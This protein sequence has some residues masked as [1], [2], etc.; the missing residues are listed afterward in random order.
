MRPNLSCRSWRIVTAEHTSIRAYVVGGRD[1]LKNSDKFRA[2]HALGRPQFK[3]LAADPHKA[4]EI[5]RSLKMVVGTVGGGEVRS[6]RR[7]RSELRRISHPRRVGGW[8]EEAAAAEAAAAA[9]ST[10]AHS[11]D[12]D[13]DG[14]L[15]LLRRRLGWSARQILHPPLPARPDHPTAADWP[16]VF[17]EALNATPKVRGD[18]IFYAGV[19][20][21]AA[22]QQAA[23]SLRRRGRTGEWI[24]ASRLDAIAEPA[25][26]LRDALSAELERSGSSDGSSGFDGDEGTSPTF[27]AR[28]FEKMAVLQ[29]ELGRKCAA[30]S[31]RSGDGRVSG[32]GGGVLQMRKR[33]AEV[34]SIG[35]SASHARYRDPGR[36]GCMLGLYDRCVT[37]AGRSSTSGRT[38]GSLLLALG[39]SD[40]GGP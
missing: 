20:A 31:G 14:F 40:S 30:S 9:A 17:A 16:R 22:E 6:R 26:A 5:V 34:G 10:G 33:T 1:F 37:P 35:F 21:I 23:M 18:W 36:L 2:Y 3:S 7:G 8:A 32:G 29:Q 4:L 11:E 38:C 27:F 39:D 28:S 15:V 24:G 12:G 25:Q 19:E 13:L